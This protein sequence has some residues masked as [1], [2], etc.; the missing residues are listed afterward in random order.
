[1]ETKKIIYIG[2]DNYDHIIYLSRILHKLGKNV[3]IFD[4]LD[5]KSLQATIP[6][7][8][9]IDILT[10]V[11]TYRRVD[12][13]AMQ[14]SK[15]LFDKYDV[16]L[17]SCSQIKNENDLDLF[18]QVIFVTDLYLHSLNNLN[19]MEKMF[20]NREI[21]KYLLVKD[22]VDMKI[23]PYAVSK[24]INIDIPEEN[25]FQLYF[26]YNDYVSKIKMQYDNIPSF[27]KISKSLKRY[28]IDE[29]AGLYPEINKKAIKK[30]YNKAK[31]GGA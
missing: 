5:T 30:A 20:K 16:V 22:I 6:V 10:Q 31:R 1:M 26:E 12:Y 2:T 17:A 29:V 28:L 11:A 24:Q 14:P 21:E 9:G 23:T 3:L 8:D 15:E 25:M 27:T 19:S 4:Y 13:T 7:I 18:D